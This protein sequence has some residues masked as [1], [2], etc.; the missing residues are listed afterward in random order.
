MGNRTYLY[1]HAQLLDTH[2]CIH[3]QYLSV[4][5]ADCY[6]HKYLWNI[7][8]SKYI[9]ADL[10][11]TLV[12]VERK[13]ATKMQKVK[14]PNTVNCCQYTCTLYDSETDRE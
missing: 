4:H 1:M 13:G 6:V 7:S 8:R 5:V 14:E 9:D 3:V 12:T 2:S 11:V 10:Q